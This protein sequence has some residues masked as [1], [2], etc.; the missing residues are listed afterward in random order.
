MILSDRDILAA[1]ESGDISLEPFERAYLQ[2]ASVDIRVSPRFLIFSNHRYTCIDP[3]EK[4]EEQRMKR[5]RGPGGGL[6][7]FL[8]AAPA[9]TVQTIIGPSNENGLPAT[10]V[11]LH[12]RLHGSCL[13]FT[14]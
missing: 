11:M 8:T 1:L 10:R 5:Y 7:L 3:R 4:Q 2:P 13:Q 14:Q 6:A 9:Q 12:S